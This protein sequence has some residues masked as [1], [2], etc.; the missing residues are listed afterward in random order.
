MGKVWRWKKQ[1]CARTVLD[2]FL[3]KLVRDLFAGDERRKPRRTGGA[4]APKKSQRQR[5][6]LEAIEP[7]LLLSADLTYAAYDSAPAAT[8]AGVE[9]YL[10]SGISTNYTLRAVDVAG[11]AHWKLYAKGTDLV[12]I[13]GSGTEVLDHTI[14]DASDLDVNIQ[15]SN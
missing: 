13:G 4:R 11:T 1:Q 12:P 9:G 15:R 3:D 2:S 10:A 5:F 6:S 8:K 14:N 7:R